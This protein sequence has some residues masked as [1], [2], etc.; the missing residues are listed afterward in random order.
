MVF[1]ELRNLTLPPSFI[2]W[3]RTC[4]RILVASS[5]RSRIWSRAP[6]SI[7]GSSVSPRPFSP[8]RTECGKWGPIL[9]PRPRSR[10]LPTCSDGSTRPATDC[11]ASRSTPSWT[12]RSR[13]RSSCCAGCPSSSHQWRNDPPQRC[14]EPCPYQA[15][16]LP[17]HSHHSH[18][19]RRTLRPLRPL[20]LLR[21]L[22]HP[23]LQ[24]LLPPLLH[25]NL[26]LVRPQGRHSALKLSPLPRDG[27]CK[28]G[29]F[30]SCKKQ[31]PCQ[32]VWRALPWGG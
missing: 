1:V 10:E 21:L 16:T 27:S 30:P 2:V 5:L 18:H 13:P 28:V 14:E 8:P 23:R 20:R 4:S 9:E 26:T 15:S 17:N 7:R 24:R 6:F 29:A 11:G 22:H 19:S 12:R 25:R 3:L 32:F 31:P